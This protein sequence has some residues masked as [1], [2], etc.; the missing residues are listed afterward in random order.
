[1]NSRLKEEVVKN[2]IGK[3]E[4]VLKRVR[5]PFDID[6]DE[7]AP[8]EPLDLDLIPDRESQLGVNKVP[9]IDEKLVD[10]VRSKTAVKMRIQNTFDKDVNSL[11][12]DKTQLIQ[13]L[14]RKMV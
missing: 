6:S 12:Y 3:D 9:G 7:A 11:D 13:E 8:R 4:V 14:N 1:M 2:V 10:Y 5:F